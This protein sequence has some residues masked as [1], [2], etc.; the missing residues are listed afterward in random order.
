MVKKSSPYQ[1]YDILEQ[2]GNGSFGSVHKARHKGTEKM[3]AVKV[4]KKK[5]NSSSEC[6][7]LCELKMLSSIQPHPNIVQLF[8]VYLSPLKELF[9][10]MEY[11]NGGNLYQLINQRREQDQVIKTCEV[12]SIMSQ[13][14]IAL[15]HVHQQGIF[16]RDMKP[17]NLL[18][19]YDDDTII[20]KLADFGL[21]RELKS[22]PPF[23]D[24]V[25]TR[26]YRAPEVLLGSTNYSYPI[27][28]WA[29]GTILAELASL[30]P[31]FPGQSEIDQL[32]RICKVL[33]NP[34]SSTHAMVARKRRT[35]LDKKQQ[36]FDVTAT[37]IQNNGNVANEINANEYMG[38]GGEWKEGIKLAQKMGFE[39]PKMV[40]IPLSSILSTAPDDL[41]DLLKRFLQF[42]PKRRITCIEALHHPFFKEPRAKI[43][44]NTESLQAF[45]LPSIPLS[46]FQMDSS[47]WDILHSPVSIHKLET[48]LIIEEDLLPGGS[49]IY[50]HNSSHYDA[51]KIPMSSNDSRLSIP[52]TTSFPNSLF[53]NIKPSIGATEMENE[54]KRSKSHS[55]LFSQ[56]ST[57][58]ASV[59]QPSIQK[60]PKPPQ[61]KKTNRLSLWAKKHTLASVFHNE[62]PMMF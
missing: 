26:W 33:G 8:D 58:S 46:P 29:V 51:N 54:I 47:K 57:S 1:E 31:L 13:I 6:N 62:K 55:S 27:D 10:I 30:K 22:K 11:I 17:E 40:P 20:V 52:R 21:A 19:G 7:N 38:S 43:T 49:T 41:I 15:A 4:M 35:K 5:F 45:D 25:S 28:L 16:H 50:V 24:Y 53:Q 42:D 59:L 36:G 61:I 3:V 56:N 14:L 32:F 44:T 18:I 9:V 37:T 34:G 2:I 60:D 48:P 39:Y 12:K 23:T